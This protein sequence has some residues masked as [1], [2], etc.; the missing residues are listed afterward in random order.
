MLAEGLIHFIATDA[1]GV[2]S[3]RPRM[4]PALARI[5]ELAGETTAVDLCSRLPGLVAAG[6]DVPAGRRAVAMKRSTPGGWRRL[7]SRAKAAS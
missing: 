7:F 4:S 1:H 5:T 3:R 6:Q 2:K